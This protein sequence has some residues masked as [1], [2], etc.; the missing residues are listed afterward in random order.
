M[1]ELTQKG[2][3]QALNTKTCKTLITRNILREAPRVRDKIKNPAPV[4]YDQNPKRCSRYE[5]IEVSLS[6]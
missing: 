3:F 4:L 6:L 2:I 5:Y 1:R